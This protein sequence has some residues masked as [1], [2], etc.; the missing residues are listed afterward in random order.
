MEIPIVRQPQTDFHQL[1]YSSQYFLGP[2]AVEKFDNWNIYK[3]RDDL[4]L[5]AH[6]NLSVSQSHDRNWKLTLLGYMLDP[7]NPG[8][9]DSEIIE[10]LFLNL[11]LIH[12]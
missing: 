5:T 7:N 11:S 8:F 4:W 6:P 12:I 3:I 9:T 1:L 10:S 2:R